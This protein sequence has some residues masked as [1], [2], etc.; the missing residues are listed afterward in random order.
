MVVGPVLKLFFI[1]LYEILYRKFE[2]W[3]YDYFFFLN[4]VDIDNF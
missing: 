3:S 2:G 4:K 1:F